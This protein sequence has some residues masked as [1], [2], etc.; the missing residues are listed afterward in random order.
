MKN[1]VKNLLH[2]V[3]SYQIQGVTI[4]V[5][6]DFGS[7]HK[8]QND[9]DLKRKNTK[10]LL[11]LISLIL[12]FISVLLIGRLCFSQQQELKIF[13][14]PPIFDLTLEPGQTYQ[15]KIYLK[16]KSDIA[17]PIEARVVNF[18]ASD[19]FG[20]IVFDNNP[21]NTTNKKLRD[22]NTDGASWFKIE[23]PNFILES[24]KL[25]RIDFSI[26]IPKDASRGGYYSV[27]IFEA[28]APSYYFP[29]GGGAK[30]LPQVGVLFL[31]SIGK[32]GEANFEIVEFGIQE[33]KRI[34][35]LEKL[36]KNIFRRSGVIVDGSHLPFILRVKNNDIYH[37]KTKGELMISSRNALD[38]VGNIEVKETM[39]LPG[40]IR[41]FP[42]EFKPEL[43]EK[44]DKFLP[45]FLAN[46]ISENL[47]LG[48]Y[49]VILNLHG[50]AKI[51]K[52]IPVFIFP[53]KMIPPYKFPT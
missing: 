52:E 53:W 49:K 19:E 29:E 18:T 51:Q 17:L 27:V 8:E 24:N 30:V 47:F 2:K 39:I 21:P 40:K 12:V 14:S 41:Q 22:A 44:L 28:R 32:R 36:S 23:S 5:R 43:F 3:L 42:I 48:K 1:F 31:I 25:K 7:G 33:R 10:N 26:N 50:S 35:F 34:Q 11:A 4:E 16:N 9:I 46:F 6:R 37:I 15:D 20:G 45:V 38:S 13:V